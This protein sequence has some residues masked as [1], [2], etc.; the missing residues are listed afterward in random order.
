MPLPRLR[1]RMFTEWKTWTKHTFMKPGLS[2]TATSKTWAVANSR[3]QPLPNTAQLSRVNS[4]LMEDFDGDGHRDVV[5]AGNFYGAEVQ[6]MRD[7]A[8]MGFFMKVDAQGHFNIIP[9]R[10]CGLYID[11]DVRD[12]KFIRIAGKKYML[13]ARNNDTMMVIAYGSVA[14]QSQLTAGK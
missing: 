7:D 12:M 11:G 3:W 1:W 5:M 2:P 10:Q 13:V 4:I 8:G 9:N 14:G 6:T